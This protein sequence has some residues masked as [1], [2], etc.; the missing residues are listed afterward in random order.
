MSANTPAQ[1]QPPRKPL[2]SQGSRILCQ[3]GANP[4]KANAGVVIEHCWM[5]TPKKTQES[6][7][8]GEGGGGEIGI[9]RGTST[10]KGPRKMKGHK[11]EWRAAEQRDGELGDTL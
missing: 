1:Q 8:S 9:E 6:A 3:I 2:K 11:V 5:G 4:I 7:K 10:R